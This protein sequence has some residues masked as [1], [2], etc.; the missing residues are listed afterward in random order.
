MPISSFA[1][2]LITNFE[3]L[4]PNNTVEVVVGDSYQ[5]K[6]SCSDNSLPFTPDYAD[7]W[8]H[9]DFKGGQHVVNQATGYS[10][11]EN[12]VITGLVEGSYAIKFTGW[13]QAKNGTNK[14][15]MINV[16]SE[17]I[18]KE[19]NNSFETANEM[20]STIRFGLSNV[21][22]V[23]YFR[24]T[25]N[26]L[27]WGDEITFR[28]HYYGSKENPFGYKWATFC[29]TNMA[30][31]GSLINQDQECKALV[32]TGNT[33]YLE[34]YYD[35]NRS[36]YFTY[37]EEFVAEVFVNGI[38]TE[39]IA[40]DDIE[41]KSGETKDF[42]ISLTS[43]A[44]GMVGVQFDVTLPNGFT[45]ETKES[46]V[47]QV[48][49][50]QASDMAC[51][52][53]DLGNGT[54]RFMLYS[55]SLQKLKTGELMVLNLKAGNSVA[56]GNYTV[57]LSEVAFSDADGQLTNAEG[58]T[59]TIKVTNFYPAA[60]NIEIPDIK[61]MSGKTA[62]LALSLLESIRSCVGIQFDLALPD[63]FSLEKDAT[64]KE[65]SISVYQANDMSCNLTAVGNG[66][67]RF[68]IYSNS[69]K[70]FVPGE[71]MNINLKVSEEKPLDTYSVSIQDVLLS[72]IGGNAHNDNG[73]S[74]N[75]TVLPPYTPGDVNNDGVIDSQDA[76]CVVNY[77]LEDVPSTFI[78]D[79]ADINQD[80]MI[81]V[82]D[83]GYII[84]LTMAQ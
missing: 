44:R 23:D 39:Y 60:T 9:Y 5:L 55:N 3:W 74:A 51:N 50:N 76:D 81:T 11:D 26:E 27:K 7:S 13:I 73:A 31:G 78:F 16:V 41:I 82:I 28:I 83:L 47:C 40:L 36:E 77:L 67:Y 66:V 32:S 35:Q 70:E 2:G 79:A 61:I 4:E 20:T 64:G 49:Q 59:A 69:L 12:G 80:G 21:S 17:R 34:V 22:D 42:K 14:M 24:Y 75:V 1:L 62:P 45:L 19:S 65:Y 52:V 18:E 68:M 43:I 71:L 58:T 37:G 10:I 46:T 72:D 63:G 56:L 38:P 84:N 30:S 54:Y 15:L 8:V 33:V 57:S 53:K 6:Y 25:N 48:S 29:G